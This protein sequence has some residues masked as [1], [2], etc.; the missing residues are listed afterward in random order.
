MKNSV[1][2]DQY[3]RQKRIEHW[4]QSIISSA[5]CL[6]IGAGALGNEVVKNLALLGVKKIYLVDFDTVV[7]ANLNRCVLLRDEDVLSGICKAEAVS[8]RV[9]ELNKETDVVAINSV[10]Q[11]VND[12]LYKK[13]DVVI[14]C[15]DNIASRLHLN[16]RAYFF[17]K[18]LIDGG[19]DGWFGKV[20][21]VV[22][23]DTACIEC[24]S[25]AGD[26]QSMWKRYSCSLSEISA[27]E[28]K[29]PALPTTTSVVAGIQVQEFIKLVHKVRHNYG[30]IEG[31]LLLYNGMKEDFEIFNLKKR[32]N[33]NSCG[34]Y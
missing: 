17:M 9:K 34:F 5:V 24:V 14:S 28:K 12:N 18:P 26:Y 29:M 25:G 21:V 2:D 8:K 31:K 22:P 4:D 27:A 33:C 20:Q 1:D 7:S 32:K 15:L 11:E 6:V 10:I 23:P 30:V 3:D 13:A 16:A 19:T